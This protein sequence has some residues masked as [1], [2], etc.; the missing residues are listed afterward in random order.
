MYGDTSRQGDKVKVLM[1]GNGNGP[2][3]GRAAKAT[4]EVAV[5]GIH[6]SATIIHEHPSANDTQRMS[7]HRASPSSI[8]SRWPVVGCYMYSMD[9]VRAHVG[10]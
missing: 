8:F 6:N 1:E 9:E 4:T 10:L 5:D 7:S 3:T 2:A